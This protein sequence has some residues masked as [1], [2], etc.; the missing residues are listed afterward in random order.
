MVKRRKKHSKKKRS[1]K[2]FQANVEKG[3]SNL[4]LTLLQFLT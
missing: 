2:G 3:S 1:S 4:L